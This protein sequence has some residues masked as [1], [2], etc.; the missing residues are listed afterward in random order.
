MTLHNTPLFRN[1]N[2]PLLVGDSNEYG[3]Q[4]IAPWRTS[5]LLTLHPRSEQIY[6]RTERASLHDDLSRAGEVCNQPFA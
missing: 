1:T 2:Y 5:L 6:E 4:A 3:R